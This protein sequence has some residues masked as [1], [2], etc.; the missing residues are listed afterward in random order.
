MAAAKHNPVSKEGAVHLF[1]EMNL[2]LPQPVRR[3][4]WEDFLF[5]R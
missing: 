4:L 1:R 5:N 3:F 2:M